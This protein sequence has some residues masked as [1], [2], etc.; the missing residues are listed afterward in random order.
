MYI[1]SSIKFSLCIFTHAL[2]LL[3]CVREFI[4]Y[5][6]RELL[7]GCLS[8]TLSITTLP[9]F[10]C[11]CLS[12]SLTLWKNAIMLDKKKSLTMGSWSLLGPTQ[13]PKSLSWYLVT[14]M[15]SVEERCLENI[16]L[17]VR[18]ILQ[19]CNNKTSNVFFIPNRNMHNLL[20][21]Q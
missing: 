18:S 20:D 2:S 3:F 4:F 12:I 16:V 10:L 8:L 5:L 13:M 6:L 17:I 11:L 1:Y 7:S 14:E 19:N 9:H 15:F 21:F